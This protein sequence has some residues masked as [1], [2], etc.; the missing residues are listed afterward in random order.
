MSEQNKLAE[1]ILYGKIDEARLLLNEGEK[2]SGHYF[3]NNKGQIFSSILRSKAFDLVDSLVKN[4]IIETDVYEYDSF[5]KSFFKTIATELKGDDES[6]SFLKEF[7]QKIDN[8]NDEVKDQTLLGY[9]LEQGADPAIIKCLIEEGCD[10]RYKNNAERNFIYEVVNKRMQ[11]TQQA[12]AYL[13]LLIAEGLDVNEKDIVGETPLM[14]AVKDRKK[15]CLE[16]LLQ[17]GA[18]ANEQ[19][20]KG[21][22]AFYLAVNWQQDFELYKILKQ[23]AS[24]DF[25]LENNDGERILPAFIKGVGASENQIAFLLEMLNDGA[26]IYQTGLY[27]SAPKSGVDW[28]AEKPA[29][30]LKAV[31]ENGNIDIDR[32]DDTGNTVLHKVCAFNVNYDAEAAKG[33]Y[34]KVKLLLGAG[35]DA[36]V[37]NDKD[38][39]PSALAQTD[40]LKIKTVELLMQQKV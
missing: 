6:I 20:N 18:D 31:L 19:D 12:L 30:V 25:D 16:F 1:A 29:A 23:Y 17:N 2:L 37:V 21:N 3:E 14:A 34:Q 39:T 27:Y 40:N 36:S 35:A 13:E 26:D 9:C 22:T 32:K 24:P 15:E 38:E 4:G 33:I 10:V 8:K 28:L 5:D 7:M 11:N